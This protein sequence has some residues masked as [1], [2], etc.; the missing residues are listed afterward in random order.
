MKLWHILVIWILA[1]TWSVGIAFGFYAG[2]IYVAAKL[3]GH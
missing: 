3:F 1:A 2:L